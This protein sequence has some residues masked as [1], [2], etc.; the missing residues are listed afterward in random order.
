VNKHYAA[1]N[2]KDGISKTEAIY[3]AQ[4][5]CSTDPACSGKV[6]LSTPQSNY[7]DGEWDVWFWSK[8]VV[9]LN[10]AFLISVDEKTGAVD[11][12]KSVK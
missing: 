9:A 5:E 12:T 6:R 11:K 3:I 10:H 1:V 7:N 8:D 2:Y 4:K